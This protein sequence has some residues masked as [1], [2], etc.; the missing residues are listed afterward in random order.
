MQERPEPGRHL[1]AIG[2]CQHRAGV[3]PVQQVVQPAVTERQRVGVQR[4]DVLGISGP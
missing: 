2:A 1:V 3:E 4:E